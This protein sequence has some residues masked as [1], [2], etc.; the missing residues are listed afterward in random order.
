MPR[1]QSG[2]EVTIVTLVY[3]NLKWLDFCM[4]GVDSTRQ[5]TKYRWLVVSNDG[6][7]EVRSDQRI[8]VDFMNADPK[9]WYIPRVYRAWNEG[10]RLS[11][12]PLVVNLSNDMYGSDYWLDELMDL[13]RKDPKTIPCGLLI[14]SGRIPSA[15][16][17][18]AQDFGIT[19]GTFNKAGFL[20]A[21][22]R[23]RRRGE[24]EPGRLFGPT[25]F[26]RQEW[27]DLGMYPEGNPGGVPGD[28]YLYERYQEAG[29]RWST[30][31]G[32][33]LYH[34]QLGEQSDL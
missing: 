16:P 3:R 9:E 7:P 25:L 12:T 4:E 21:A 13:K 10:F 8:T 34:T 26:E 31:R 19:P 33:V 23:L 15:M 1:V 30:C 11:P 28:R 18:Y 5:K 29:F 20:A 27:Y 17:E 22:A 24:Y 6:T 14:E 2:A 32:A